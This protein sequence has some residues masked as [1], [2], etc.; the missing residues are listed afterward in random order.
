[1]R[2]MMAV[3]MVIAAL[4]PV[5]CSE[6][7]KSEQQSSRERDV[8]SSELVP[9]Y[10]G[11]CKEGFKIYSQNQFS[12]GEGVYGTMIRRTLNGNGESAGLRG[13]DELRVVGWVRTEYVFYPD[14][15]AGLRGEVWYYVPNLPNGGA[16]WVPDAGVRAVKTEPAPNDLDSYFHPETQAAPQL[17]ECRLFSR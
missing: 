12:V 2:R 17:P 16:G 3:S 4:L 6:S 10:T 13:N 8:M 14:N 11:G 7:S 1:M 9:G 5:G 15:P